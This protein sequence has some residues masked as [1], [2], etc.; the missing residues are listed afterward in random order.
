MQNIEL[1]Q[2]GVHWQICMWTA[3]NLQGIMKVLM[4]LSKYFFQG[5]CYAIE[6]EE[7]LTGYILL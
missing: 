5:R 4:Q 7:F 6:F 3:L 1:I 2:T